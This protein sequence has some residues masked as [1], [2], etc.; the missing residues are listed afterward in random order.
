MNDTTSE[1]VPGK[2]RT[3]LIVMWVVFSLLLLGTGGVA[4]VFLVETNTAARNQVD[5]AAELAEAKADLTVKKRDLTYVST[6]RDQARVRYEREALK[7]Q[8]DQE[9]YDYIRGILLQMR[10]KNSISI[11]HG[12]CVE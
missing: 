7:A 11:D 4:A 5:Q 6:Q 12:N 8:R 9:C 3:G 1:A 2:R 10:T